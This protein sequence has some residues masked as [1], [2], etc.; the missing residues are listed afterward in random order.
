MFARDKEHLLRFGA[1]QNLIE[2]I[3][4]GGFSRVAQ[5]ASVDDEIRLLRQ[6]VDLIDGG[7]QGGRYIGIRRFVE[8]HVAVADLD[9]VEFSLGRILLILAKGL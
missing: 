7:L 2:R 8:A 6:S 5:V 1:L 4:F 9:E 3:E